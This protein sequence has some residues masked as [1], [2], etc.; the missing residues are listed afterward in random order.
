MP[1]RTAQKIGATPYS[2]SIR[3]HDEKTI[4]DAVISMLT[5]TSAKLYIAS[6]ETFV[7][8][9]PEKGK[10]T[11][12]GVYFIGT[13]YRTSIG[14]LSMLIVPLLIASTIILN[15]MLGS[16][17]ERKKE[18]AVYNAVGLNPTHIGL[19]F[20]AESF[21]YSVIGSV[22][23]YLIGQ[24]L[25]LA[26]NKFGL[27]SDI[28]LNFSSL[29]VAYVILFTI[30]IV[31]LSTLYPASVATK[32]AVPSGKRKWSMPPNNG[33]TMQV[34]FPFI[35]QPALLPG[36]M[37]YL[38][39]YFG[40]YTEAS[41]G[42][43]IADIEKKSVG[44][45]PQGRP[46]YTLDYLVALAPFDLGVTQKMSFQASYDEVVQS[47]RITMTTVRVSG[48]DSNWISTNKPALEKLRK[49]MLQWRN[50]DAGQHELFVRK[51]RES[52]A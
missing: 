51:G 52:F 32:A 22:G 44:T 7:V 9:D 50:L 21:V 31:L 49:H 40:Q 8:G 19:F 30:S 2:L 35:Y 48:Q 25:S 28:N 29:S 11:K 4:W 38:E 46:V 39:E 12:P 42:E 6:R 34:V 23:G 17:F 5:A 24:F 20:L 10:P 15:T 47:F 18:I 26:L 36:I 3:L 1:S 33:T 41:T 16:V 45:D 13:G 27:V 14:G 37:R 43:L